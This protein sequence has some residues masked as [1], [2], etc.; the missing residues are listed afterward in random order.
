MKKLMNHSLK[1]L[2]LYSALVLAISIPVYYTAISLLW[3]YE[4][5]HEH[6]IILTPEANREDSLLI[7]GA[8]TLLTVVF[9]VLLLVGFIFIN[10]RISRQLW[11]PF[12]N[13]LGRIRQF[14]LHRQQNIRFDSTDI[15][16]FN[17]LNESLDKLLSANISTFSQQKE[18]ADNASHE[19]QTPLAIAQS[20]MEILLQTKPL[21]S[22][23]YEYIEDAMKALTRV[24]RI[25]KNLLLL[26]KIENSQYSDTESVDCSGLVRQTAAVFA[27]LSQGRDISVN[28][29]VKD[30][31]LIEC[32]RILVELLVQNLVNN[33]IRHSAPG[34]VI[35]I[36]LQE[37]LLVI[38]NK[39][40]MPL[41]KD[42]LFKRFATANA[43]SPGTGLGLALVQQ[44][45][46][47][48]HWKIDYR[49][50]DNCHVFSWRF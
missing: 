28:V 18:F 37:N 50:T 34:T 13:S 43:H 9:F 21:T 48:Y 47:R 40:N 6:N 44:I 16:E 25:N 5:K 35:E 41:D 20:K 46:N 31:V 26:T 45:C 17:E 30:H 39:G 33:A 7:I 12:Y 3:E 10:R 14:D 2:L 11:Q 32:N 49:F 15:A 4:L 36:N 1:R 29:Q 38:S 22:E 42:Q 23:Q 19:L 27:G 24:N 8:V